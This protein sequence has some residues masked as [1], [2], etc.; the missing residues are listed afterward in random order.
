MRNSIEMSKK[1]K[2][3]LSI[4]RIHPSYS[5]EVLIRRYGFPVSFVS[6][7]RRIEFLNVTHRVVFYR[8]I[9]VLPLIIII[10][11]VGIYMDIS[12]KAREISTSGCGD[13]MKRHD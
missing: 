8:N 11:F 4:Q 12:I 6:K 5:R 3:G 13:K 7:L 2:R 9:G 10:V 1:N